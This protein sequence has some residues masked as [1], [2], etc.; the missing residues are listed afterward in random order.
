[1]FPGKN[2]IKYL[3]SLKI[4]KFRDANRQFIVEGEKIVKDTL[5]YKPGLIRQIFATPDWLN[6][7]GPLVSG[8]SEV[9]ETDVVDLS[10]VSSFDTP[11]AVMALLDFQERVPDYNRIANSLSIALDTVQ[12]P[13]NMGTIIRTADWFGIKDVFCNEG[14][15]DIYNPKVIQASMGAVLN[16][17]VHYTDL[18][19][20]LNK[21]G[22]F[23]D[24][25]IAGTFMNGSSIY[26]IPL[27]HK[28][29]LM[30]GNESK[31]I[32][33]AFRHLVHNRLTIPPG[34]N[35]VHVES[36]NV[37]SSVAVVLSI[38]KSKR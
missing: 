1:M 6:L 34:N 23:T 38:L 17:N 18:T 33:D 30:F 25:F 22:A 9:F 3:S 20:L 7:N 4:K 37:A 2:K 26:E 5:Q 36:L 24:Y 14:C 32:S 21:A 16:V 31:G 15:A 11:P 8:L 19:Q 29:L 27:I 28:G 12:D 13:G 35:G 10:K